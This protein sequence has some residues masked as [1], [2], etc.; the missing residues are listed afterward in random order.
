[1]FSFGLSVGPAQCVQPSLYQELSHSLTKQAEQHHLAEK[2][3]C[4]RST[5]MGNYI[6][7]QE[8]EQT[9]PN[10]ATEIHGS[11]S[12]EH[13]INSNDVLMHP[14]LTALSPETRFIKPCIRTTSPLCFRTTHTN[15]LSF[16]KSSVNHIIQVILAGPSSPMSA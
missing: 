2:C 14:V 6:P 1:M 9:R 10:V 8:Q 5:T 15:S 11:K 16:L 12:H 4:F 7:Q 13:G 3:L